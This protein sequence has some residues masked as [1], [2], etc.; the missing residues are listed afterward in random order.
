MNRI[1][2]RAD[3][4]HAQGERLSLIVV[5]FM[6][7]VL[8][9]T[10]GRAG[11]E[12]RARAVLLPSWGLLTVRQTV[13][14]ARLDLSMADLDQDLRG[15][16]IDGH[17]RARR[18]LSV[19]VAA[20]ALLASIAAAASTTRDHQADRFRRAAQLAGVSSLAERSIVV[21][22]TTG[23]R[24][25]GPCSTSSSP[26]RRTRPPELR[27]DGSVTAFAQENAW[28]QARTALVLM[29]PFP[30]SRWPLPELFDHSSDISRPAEVFRLKSEAYRLAAGDY[31][32]RADQYFV[33]VTLLALVLTLMGMSATIGDG[34]HRW[35]L[36]TALVPFA[37]AVAVVAWATLAPS[38][39]IDDAAIEKVAD[40]N[41]RA[42]SSTPRPPLPTTT[43]PSRS[44]PT[45]SPPCVP[46]RPPAWWPVALVPGSTSS[47]TRAPRRTGSRSPTWNGW[48]SWVEV[49]C[50][51]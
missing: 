15:P 11:S 21:A 17:G 43:P 42:R 38:E 33:A 4:L 14:S 49:I 12:Q 35:L 27:V 22:D 5:G 36:L 6:A 31:G 19:A 48:S 2:A 18:R 51:P 45:T 44:S 7:V 41:T 29:A 24:A 3:E 39:A 9:L 46:G 34:V 10:I 37:A 23:L 25:V 40:G 47:R 50:R 1:V 13:A 26:V 20:V 30:N 32:R 28:R 16:E 8:L